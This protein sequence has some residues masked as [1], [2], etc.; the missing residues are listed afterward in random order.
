MVSGRSA[1]GRDSSVETLNA[2]LKEDPPELSASGQSVPPGVERLIRRCLEKSSEERFQSA[3]DLAFA[4]DAFSGASGAAA[5]H[6]AAPAEEAPRRW[7]RPA[8]AVALLA[9]I[10][11]GAYFAGLW[12]GRASDRAHVSF[13]AVTFRPQTIFN[14]A[15]AP[16]GRTIVFSAALQGNVPELFLVRPE[17]P[18]PQPL[19]LREVNLLSM[20]SK[21]ELAVLTHA[22]YYHRIFSGTLATMPLGGGAPRELLEGV[23]QADWTPDGSALA[24]IRQV[25]G[26]YRLEFPIGKVLYETA[27][28]LSDLR[29]SPQGD[30]IA[31]FEHPIRFDDRGSVDVVDL[32]GKKTVVAPGYSGLEGMAW[33]PDGSEVLFSAE[34][35]GIPFSI[36]A[37]TPSGK[38]RRVL[39]SAGGL[40][41]RDVSRTGRWL[42]TR[43]DLRKD[44]MVLA[45]GA[46]A[47]RNLSWLGFSDGPCLSGDGRLLAFTEESLG[48][49]YTACFRKSDGSPVVR[50]GDGW[51]YDI[52]SD[53]KWVLAIIDSSPPVIVLYPTGPG[54][55]RKLPSGAV[56]SYETAKWFADGKRV[57]A[58]GNEP[59]RP[60]RCY[61]QDVTGGQ[62]RAITPE[63]TSQGLPSPDGKFILARE[64]GGKFFLYPVG[65]GQPQPVAGLGP[66]RVI[67]WSADGRSLF[68]FRSAEI[69]GRIERFELA[70]ARRTLYKAL[71]P[72]DPTGVLTVI[73]A[74]VSDDARS[75]AYTYRHH[76]STLFVLEGA[77]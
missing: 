6:P 16:D 56:E 46:R 67:R 21:N 74:S 36:F 64:A 52:S 8:A 34:T 55:P 69:P 68:V 70:T 10:A 17:N 72:A 40:I 75:C 14:A 9:V 76:L 23:D 15:L 53:G 77:R 54:E 35:G 3:R 26:K 73:N 49:Y 20:S 58:C 44:L 1:F 22:R 47:E 59:G 7:L 60:T 19:G 25:N 39:E 62:P 71:V 51:S 28:Y 61:V 30:R 41:I 65:G 2:I 45:P 50:L 11:A 48:P 66:E 31:F 37:V 32:A 33:S 42:V 18:E 4:L 29:F 57:L 38:L 5:A 13:Q 43:D 63:G 24:I 12:R 27:G